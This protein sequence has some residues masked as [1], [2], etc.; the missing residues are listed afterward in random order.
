[1][2]CLN[3]FSTML[4][5]PRVEN[6]DLDTCQ[7]GWLLV[8]T[9][10]YTSYLS[11]VMPTHM[12]YV[13]PEFLFWC[14]WTNLPRHLSVYTKKPGPLLP[15]QWFSPCLHDSCLVVQALKVHDMSVQM[16]AYMLGC[17]NRCLN[18]GIYASQ[19]SRKHNISCSIFLTVSFPQIWMD[20]ETHEHFP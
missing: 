2:V 6:S 13:T 12:S 20:R 17:L 18:Y 4:G 5:V 10:A 3:N 16:P 19:T 14:Q 11:A 15:R 8:Q 1:M 9:V 7:L